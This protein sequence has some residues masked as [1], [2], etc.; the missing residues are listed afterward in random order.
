MN[1]L[2]VFFFLLICLFSNAQSKNKRVPKASEIA[3]I[4]RTFKEI[5]I[6]DQRYRKVL[7]VG[8]MDETILAEID[9]VYENHGMEEAIRYEEGLDL[10]LPKDIADSLWQLQHAIDFRNHLFLHAIFDR[11][12]WIDNELVKEYNYVQL[13]LLMHPPKDWD[14]TTYLAEYSELFF[15]EVKAGRM[16]AK[17]FAMFYDNIKGKILREPQ[18]YG[19]NE[20]FDPETMQILPPEIV[21]VKTTNKARKKIGLPPLKEGEYRLV[22]KS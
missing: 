13:L 6:S 2:T 11:Y 7:S 20:Q 17:T 14:V 4:K 15:E 12:G 10:V 19:T 18:L 8:T 16:P 1:K 22:S 5:S 21:D 3:F 9:S